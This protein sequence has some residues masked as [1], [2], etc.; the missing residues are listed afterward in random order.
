MVFNVQGYSI[1]QIKIVP[2]LLATKLLSFSNR[3]ASAWYDSTIVS[4]SHN[5][6]LTLH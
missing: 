4:V 5:K 3:A 6:M 2:A 1:S